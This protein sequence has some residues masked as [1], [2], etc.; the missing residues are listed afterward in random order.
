MSQQ[1]DKDMRTDFKTLESIALDCEDQFVAEYED[2]FLNKDYL[3]G[4]IT[5]NKNDPIK[6]FIAES[7]NHRVLVSF[8]KNIG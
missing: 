3:V 4:L 2:F 5:D 1:T 6:Y 7:Y 8:I